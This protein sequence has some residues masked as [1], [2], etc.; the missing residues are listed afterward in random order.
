MK[1]ITLKALNDS[2]IQ[3]RYDKNLNLYAINIISSKGLNS[4]HLEL[5]KI[6]A[7]ALLL[8][9]TNVEIEPLLSVIQKAIN[10]SIDPSTIMNVG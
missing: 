3:V 5:T 4:S 8:Q 2:S 7:N 9:H 10:L 6:Q 1:K